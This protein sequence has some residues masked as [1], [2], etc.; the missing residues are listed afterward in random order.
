M[1]NDHLFGLIIFSCFHVSLYLHW[2]NAAGHQLQL[3]HLNL[4]AKTGARVAQLVTGKSWILQWLHQLRGSK[5]VWC[6][7]CVQGIGIGG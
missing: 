5:E 7:L 1:M 4:C 3:P 2:K 6:A